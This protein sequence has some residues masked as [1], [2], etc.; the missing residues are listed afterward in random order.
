MDATDIALGNYD[1]RVER[2]FVRIHSRLLAADLATN[3][4]F[5]EF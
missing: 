2:R 3:M 1:A 5:G 4:E